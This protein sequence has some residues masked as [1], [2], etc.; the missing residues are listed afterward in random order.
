LTFERP[1][2]LATL[3]L[4][5]AAV[6]AYLHVQRRSVRY[7]IRFPN[8][9]VLAAAAGGQ[10]SWRRHL[11]GGLLVLALATLAVATARPHVSRL[12]PVE[13]ASV[14]LVIDT[15]RSME[16]QDVK[17]SRLAAAKEAAREFLARVPKQLRV[18]VVVFSGDVNVTAFPTTNHALVR[19]SIDAIGPYTNFGFGGTA[20]GDAL[21]RAVELAR[22]AMRD[23]HLASV[24]ASRA[25]DPEGAVSILFLSDG[26]QNRGILLPAEGARRAKEAGIPVY[27]VALGTRGSRS[28][29]PGPGAGSSPG[30]QFGSRYRAPD[31]ATLRMIAR[32][33][34]G[35]FFEARSREALSSAYEGLGSRLGRAPRKTEVTFAFVG[36]AAAVLAAAALLSA[37]VWPRLP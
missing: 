7:A 20:I 16:S 14:I 30:G 2:L 22:D 33:T 19:Q 28:P 26:R 11:P 13:R 1:W 25:A 18:G 27:T 29:G 6:G 15:S 24:A 21:A 32:T 3:L 8:L 5:V 12:M 31:P 17:P 4:V 23:R 35:E 9:D 37:F 10:R 36:A 34:G